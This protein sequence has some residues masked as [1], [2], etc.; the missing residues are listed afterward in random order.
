MRS[1]LVG[2]G[3]AGVI[4][5]SME[6]KGWS[7]AGTGTSC[8]VSLASGYPSAQLNSIASS[9]DDTSVIPVSRLMSEAII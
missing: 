1:M 3:L 8:G 6:G 5:N 4:W 9:R 7:V 2:R